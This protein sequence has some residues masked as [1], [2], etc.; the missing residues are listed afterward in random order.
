MKKATNTFTKYTRNGHV[1]TNQAN[2]VMFHNQ[3]NLKVIVNNALLLE[4]GDS[5]T[6]SQVN[7][8]VIDS[9]NYSIVFVDD[10]NVSPLPEIV[11][12]KTVLSNINNC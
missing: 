8:D 7:T 1:D 9:T 12:I 5:I 4:P 10:P 2:C 3:G 6:I 11:V